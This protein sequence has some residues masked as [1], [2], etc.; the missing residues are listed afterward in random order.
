MEDP[1]STRSEQGVNNTSIA[2]FCRIQKTN[3]VS[4]QITTLS[5]DFE[6][7]GC[8]QGLVGARLLEAEFGLLNC[9]VPHDELPAEE[10]LGL[11]NLSLRNLGKFWQKM[12]FQ[13][14]SQVD[15]AFLLKTT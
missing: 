3:I 2:I 11:A 1:K 10:L 13:C 15:N 9:A 8:L 14:F 7:Q 6:P 5:P 12:R 4:R